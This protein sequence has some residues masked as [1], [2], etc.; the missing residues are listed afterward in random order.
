[1]Y[2]SVQLGDTQVHLGLAFQALIPEPLGVTPI[3][4]P[5]VV[6]VASCRSLRC[7]SRV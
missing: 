5:S 3:S 2:Q 1:M 7:A 6:P 4:F